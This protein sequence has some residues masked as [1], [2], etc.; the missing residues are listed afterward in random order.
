MNREIYIMQ[1]NDGPMTKTPD[2]RSRT[3]NIAEPLLNSWHVYR[4]SLYHSPNKQ[5]YDY[6]YIHKRDDNQIETMLCVIAELLNYII[7]TKK[8]YDM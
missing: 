3:L 4:Q 5:T 6:E 8:T 2:T 7:C 1:F